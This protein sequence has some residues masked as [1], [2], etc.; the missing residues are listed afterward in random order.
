MTT[1]TVVTNSYLYNMSRKIEI[2]TLVLEYILKQSRLG[3][4]PSS[5]EILV[6][7]ENCGYSTSLRTVQRRLEDLQ[8]EDH[9]DQDIKGGY[10]LDEEHNEANLSSRERLERSLAYES[11]WSSQNHFHPDGYPIISFEAYNNFRGA[12]NL[13]DL[14][15]AICGNRVIQFHYKNYYRPGADSDR[16]VYP[17]FLKEYLNRWYL[18]AWDTAKEEQRLFGIDRISELSFT[19]ETFQAKPY[20]KQT[21]SNFQNIIGL[22]YGDGPDH[23]ELMD[24]IIRCEDIQ[25]HFLESLPLHHSQQK[26]PG[27]LGTKNQTRFRYRIAPNYELEQ[28][29]LSMSSLVEV[30]EPVWYR[31]AFKQT[32]QK[33]LGLYK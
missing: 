18:M 13:R 24:L 33:L 12:E 7:L 32:V 29:L 17:L 28:R 20:Y 30:I 27:P 11:I 31:N 2:K 8:M 15:A 21:W 14:L 10:F 9:I 6:F 19:E 23:Y 25:I 16:R 3:H 22:R 5:K 1:K 26:I 4:H